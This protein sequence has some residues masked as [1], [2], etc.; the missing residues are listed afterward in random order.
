M[1]RAWVLSGEGIECEKETLRFLRQKIFSYETVSEVPVHT[2]RHH[3]NSFFSKVQTN[4]LIFF[5]GGFS[6]SDHFGSGRLL[7]FKLKEWGFFEELKKHR[8]N[9]FGACNGFQVLT[10]AGFFGADT[11]LLPNLNKN[12]K[13]IGFV[14]RWVKTLWV[15][16]ST[17]AKN[18]FYLPVRHGEGR[19]HLPE[20]KTLPPNVEPILKYNDDVFSNGSYENIAGLYSR[21]K[22][23]N[24]FLNVAA[25]MPHA[26]IALRPMDQP[27]FCG[28]EF[29]PS[30]REQQSVNEEGHGIQFMK[31]LLNLFSHKEFS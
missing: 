30:F 1:S 20:G 31:Q 15:H 11:K 29:M 14:N 21:I 17:A 28:P 18:E 19:L 6:F 12:K 27:D 26:E 16:D 10:E 24:G 23:D 5:P 25:M 4:D 9:V 22:T 13:P 3:L 2:F 8:V 7:A